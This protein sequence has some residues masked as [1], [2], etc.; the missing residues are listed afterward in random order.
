V[1][2]VALL[3][4]YGIP[5]G[6]ANI[7]DKTTSLSGKD[8]QEQHAAFWKF[9]IIAPLDNLNLFWKPHFFTV[10]VTGAGEGTVGKEVP[11]L[12]GD[13]W[14]SPRTCFRLSD[15][16]DSLRSKNMRAHSVIIA[17]SAEFLA[18]ILRDALRDF[19]I[20]PVVTAHSEHE[21]LEGIKNNYPRFVFLENC[22]RGPGTEEF[23]LRTV[24]RDR[25]VRIVVWSAMAVKPVLAARYILAGAE[26]YFSLREREENIAEIL[27][28]IVSGGRYCPREVQAVIDSDTYFPDMRGKLTLREMEI[29]KLI[30]SEQK[31][32]KIAE[33]LGICEATVK[34][35]KAHIYRKC[36][37]N[38]SVDIL[39]YGLTQGV[40]RP[41]DL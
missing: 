12:W 5:P 36:G 14:Y 27:K 6:V 16:R 2:C 13:T 1:E 40:I 37:G 23:I 19:D 28:V 3:A 41:E 17:T 31:N 9:T 26:S 22:F 11:A 10:G 8:T 24:K 38:T 33:A 21:L 34:N 32:R 30:V 15:M 29:I 18:D 35:H 25:D 39:Q 20:R 4:K 7:N